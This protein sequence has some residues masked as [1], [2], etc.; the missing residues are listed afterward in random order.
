[1]SSSDPD[2]LDA[3]DP[4]PRRGFW[5]LGVVA[6]AGAGTMVVELGAVRLLAPWFG[7]SS[8]VW[9]NVIGVVLAAL[10]LGYAIGGRLATTANPA[11]RLGSVLVIAGA[12]ASLLPLVAGP[13]AE[14]FMP[15]GVPLHRA[16]GV[17]VWGSL[18]CAAVLFLPAAAA[19]GCA[20]P[21]AVEAI[22]R[23]SGSGAGAAGGRVLAAST[24]GSLAG[25]FSTTHLLIPGMGITKTF[26]L[27]SAC[28]AASGMAILLIG[29]R[30]IASALWLPLAIF[31][32][33]AA[34]STLQS[35]PFGRSAGEGETLL[36]AAESSV[37]SIRA[38]ETE[39]QEGQG[40]IRILRV[41]ESL[42][43]FQSVWTKEPGLLPQGHYYNLFALPLAWTTQETREAPG[44]WDMLV[45][46][47]G[48]GTSVRV[49][50]G[51]KAPETELRSV[52]IEIDEAVLE[53]GEAYFELERGTESRVALGDLDGRA[54]LRFLD[55]KFDQVIVD[56]Y[57]NNMEIPPHLATVEAFRE[58][59]GTLREDGWLTVNIGGFG[60][61]DPVV[62]AIA[63]SAHEGLES[64]VYLAR[65]PLSRNW[66]VFGR[67]GSGVPQP[68]ERAF[69][70]RGGHLA[71]GVDRVIPSLEVPGA[72]IP[73]DSAWADGY[74]LTDDTSDTESLQASS[75][76]SAAKRLQELDD[77]TDGGK[78]VPLDP[79]S[80]RD[81]D[82][83]EAVNSFAAKADFTDALDAAASIEHPGLRAIL[84]ARVH[85]LGGSPLR[86]LELASEGLQ[87]VPNDPGLLSMAIDAGLAVGAQKIS[88]V[89]LE[90]LRAAVQGDDRWA[91]RI[92]GYS[93]Q[94]QEFAE[95]GSR[96]KGAVRRAQ[97]AVLLAGL[98][99]MAGS[100]WAAG[101]TAR[102]LRAA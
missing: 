46:G 33:G 4:E 28:L 9:T 43:S 68:G 13:V 98:I 65:V 77:Q 39:G 92:S 53:L 11:H 78:A 55:R 63:A 44:T 64:T 94:L 12:L 18:A 17:L 38:I 52:G 83:A 67:K 50:E 90:R 7:T 45:I 5:L 74:S 40:P 80:P 26:V 97:W 76:A 58:I 47:L 23:M 27:A 29:E 82:T 20:G 49:L 14:F 56:A 22:Q 81:L 15:S 59:A 60:P 71:H 19:L 54:A 79:P 91:G 100:L 36:A 32:G 10:A 70:S 88:T 61:D 75:I 87:S 37:Q 25:T 1:M 41:N 34:T 73:V 2:Q 48:A 66:V 96:S 72:W 85:W 86:A 16:A 69:G 35:G 51:T 57:A 95:E 89:R 93:A 30:R 8:S 6:L 101:S 42:D 102:S 31:A 99:G 84:E 21:L 3:Q 62:R 24:L